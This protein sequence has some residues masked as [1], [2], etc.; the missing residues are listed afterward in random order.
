[1]LTKLK[2]LT[3]EA[4][5][6]LYIAG[7]DRNAAA[8]DGAQARV[9]EEVDHVGLGGL[10]HGEDGARLKPQALFARDGDLADQAL[11]GQLAQKQ[12]RALLVAADLAQG[13]GAGAELERL[14]H[15]AGDRSSCLL[16]LLLRD[17]RR[18]EDFASGGLGGSAAGRLNTAVLRARHLGLKAF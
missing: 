7:L 18:A 16:G 2:M 15:A 8:V 11:E 5:R 17:D 14:L 3:T 4:A 6:E 12:L 1:M 9:G 13:D 10:L